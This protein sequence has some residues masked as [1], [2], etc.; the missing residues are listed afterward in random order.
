MSAR[1]AD[2]SQRYVTLG[3]L[4]YAA[5]AGVFSLSTVADNLGPLTTIA[6]LFGDVLSLAVYI[7]AFAAKATHRMSHNPIYDYFMGAWL[8][9]RVYV[10]AERRCARCGTRRA[11]FVAHS[12]VP[13][14]AQQWQMRACVRANH[15][16]PSV[17]QAWRRPE[18]D[19]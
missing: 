18:D 10:H 6:V 14:P 12:G 1:D 5:Y 16:M 3:V 8:N 2:P 9:P 17:S 15:G 19:V 7:G 4:A 13:A 11:L